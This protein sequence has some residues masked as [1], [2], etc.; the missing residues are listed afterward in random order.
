M[1]QVHAPLLKRTPLAALLLVVVEVMKELPATMVLR[2]FNSDT[3]AVVAYQLARDERLGE[4][5]LPSLALVVVG[6]IPVVL[7]SR[8]L[9]QSPS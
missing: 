3:L 1:R 6:L 2:P 8:T 5:S 7:L 4:A 9:R